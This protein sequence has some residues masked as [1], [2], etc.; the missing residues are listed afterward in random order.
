MKLR[1]LY[2]FDSSN[3]RKTT[4]FLGIGGGNNDRQAG[5]GDPPPTAV[6]RPSG[7]VPL[8]VSFGTKEDGSWYVT[9]APQLEEFEHADAVMNGLR[10]FGAAPS[11]LA[12]LERFASDLEE[13]ANSAWEPEDEDDDGEGAAL[14]QQPDYIK[15][16]STFANM[17]NNRKGCL[18][19]WTSLLSHGLSETTNLAFVDATDPNYPKTIKPTR[20]LTPRRGAKVRNFSDPSTWMDMY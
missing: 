8:V 10:E 19:I 5:A 17:I 16:L 6:K 14:E 12:V 1:D 11:S 20:H 4:G 2:E 9:T 7:N 18:I 15:A 3:I 13:T